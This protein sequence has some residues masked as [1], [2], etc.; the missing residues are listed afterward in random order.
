MN[1]NKAYKDYEW[2]I[3]VL[4][5]VNSKCQLECVNKC[6]N[7]WETKYVTDDI[8]PCDDKMIHLLRSRFWASFKNKELRFSHY[9]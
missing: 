8:S 9:M 4:N 7:L 3:K 5:S 2:V 6:F 1:L